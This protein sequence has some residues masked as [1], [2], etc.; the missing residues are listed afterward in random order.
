MMNLVTLLIDFTVCGMPVRL[1]HA[2]VSYIYG[3]IYILFT[4]I[5]WRLGGTGGNGKPYIYPILDYSG[6]P[7]LAAGTILG[8]GVAIFLIHAFWTGLYILKQKIYGTQ[9]ETQSEKSDFDQFSDD[10]YAVNNSGA[11]PTEM[12]TVGGGYINPAANVD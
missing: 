9:K 1:H 12:E 3:I 11:W 7:G 5:Y 8:L 10:K 6:N 2:W 4:I